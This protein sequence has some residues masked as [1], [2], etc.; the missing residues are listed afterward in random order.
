MAIFETVQFAIRQKIKS[1][2]PLT[3]RILLIFR[4]RLKRH[5][6]STAD[7]KRDIK[8]KYLSIPSHRFQSA[9]IIF[10]CTRFSRWWY[11]EIRCLIFLCRHT[12]CLFSG[13][14]KGKWVSEREASRWRSGEV[15]HSI[16]VNVRACSE[17]LDIFLS[18]LPFNDI[19]VKTCQKTSLF[20]C[21]CII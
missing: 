9:L 19:K 16:Q 4:Q 11:Q 5:F 15:L 2:L 12:S 14:D 21:H 3:I 6:H 7:A 8:Q 13:D 20:Y 1:T 18:F 17:G 10:F